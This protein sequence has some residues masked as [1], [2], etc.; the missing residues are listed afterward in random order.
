MSE[1]GD[2]D[3]WNAVETVEIRV[4]PLNLPR[5]L[6]EARERGAKVTECEA[7]LWQIDDLPVIPDP[8]VDLD[9]PYAVSYGG[10]EFWR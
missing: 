4:H 10:G 2:L 3:L 7:G 1:H 6:N 8:Y 9:G 5:V